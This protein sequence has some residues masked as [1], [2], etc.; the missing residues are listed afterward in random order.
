ML[1]EPYPGA[2]R[3]FE[4]R[5]KVRLPAEKAE[6]AETVKCKSDYTRRRFRISERDLEKFGYTAGCPGCRAVNWGTTAVN[7]SEECRKIW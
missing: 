5:P 6:F 3:G 7:H 1:W 2:M 4:L